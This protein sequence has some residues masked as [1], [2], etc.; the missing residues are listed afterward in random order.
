MTRSYAK[1]Q[2]MFQKAKQVMPW[3]VAS[4]WR[5]QGETETLVITRG[6]GGH[7]WD[8]DDN[9]YI[10]FRC[11]FG[12]V[13]LGHGDKRVTD[14]VSEAITKG[15]TYSFTHPLE[16]SVAE[17]IIRMCPG[18]EK[19][20][21]ANSGTEATMHALRIARAHT[22]REVIIQFEG[23]YHGLHDYVMFST[24][25]TPSESLGSIRSP[26]RAEFSS[27]IPSVIRDLV[28]ILPYNDFELLEKTVKARWGQIAAIIVEP[29]LGGS[30]SVMPASG[31]L[32]HIRKLCDDFGIV[33]IMD[34]VK[35]GFRIARGGATEYFGV[36]GDLMTY[37]KAVANGFPLAAI[38]GSNE[39][40]GT[41]EPGRM[42]LAGTYC[43]N[44]AATA[45]ADATLEVLESTDALKAIEQRGARL[46]EGL[47][48]ILSEAAMEHVMMG[49]PAMFSFLLGPSQAP[50][51]YRGCL[52][53]DFGLYRY[54]GRAMRERGVEYV[55]DP[56]E[57]W[58]LCEAHSD[59]DV[60][61]A[62]NAFSEAVKEAKKAV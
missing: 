54:L 9:E 3:G 52:D 14:R 22:G 12:P 56:L 48:S 47:S 7:I 62:L 10:D 50:T 30:C 8:A 58:F 23:Q 25:G 49:P 32:E 11:S 45:A 5:Y 55:H 40:M 38:G 21:F 17:R 44:V 39:V 35:T 28:I 31:W 33:M 60:D 26:L 29:L 41:I 27:G 37:A 59:K 19:V 4:D 51:D 53:S 46:K 2:A 1:T 42:G 6:Q 57:P 36:K 34:E 61:E 43:G 20:R 15:T 16:I 18:V 13:I 24:S